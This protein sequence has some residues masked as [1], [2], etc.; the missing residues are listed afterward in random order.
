MKLLG[1]APREVYRLYSE[2]AFLTGADDPAWAER[3]QAAP[4]GRAVRA[5][6][7]AGLV[8]VL[9][10]VGALIVVNARPGLAGRK[11]TVSVERLSARV[12]ANRSPVDALRGRLRARITRAAPRRRVRGRATSSGH[13]DIARMPAPAVTPGAA[14]VSHTAPAR[15]QPTAATVAA[16]AVQPAAQRT[17][18]EF[19][20][21]R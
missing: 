13:A 1:A 8:G 14:D 5:A 9:T 4:G 6:G 3:A 21:E 7:A 2:D 10:T 16:E 19:G 15:V 11:P 17:G 20:F 12:S 18:P